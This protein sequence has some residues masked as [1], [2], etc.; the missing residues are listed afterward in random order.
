V[1]MSEHCTPKMLSSPDFCSFFSVIFRALLPFSELALS[2]LPSPS[3]TGNRKK[4]MSFQKTYI[5]S[6]RMQCV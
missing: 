2:L 1:R 3:Q 6:S 5:Q 4:E